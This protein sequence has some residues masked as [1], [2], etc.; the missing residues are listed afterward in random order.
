MIKAQHFVVND[1]SIAQHCAL[2][3]SRGAQ[4]YQTSYSIQSD[5]GSFIE[6]DHHEQLTIQSTDTIK[7]IADVEEGV[8]REVNDKIKILE[9]EIIEKEEIIKEKEEILSKLQGGENIEEKD[10]NDNIS[11]LVNKS[12]LHLEAEG[13]RSE[14]N[15]QCPKLLRLKSVQ[16]N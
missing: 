2:Q 3:F 6:D 4:T 7:I 13:E 10:E 15:S 8:R 14:I 12:E 5:S 1:G 16:V 9:S 11:L